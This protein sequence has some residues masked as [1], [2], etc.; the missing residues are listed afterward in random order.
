MYSFFLYVYIYIYSSGVKVHWASDATLYFPIS[1][2]QSS[3][4]FN[5]SFTV[6]VSTVDNLFVSCSLSAV[7]ALITAFELVFAITSCAVI[8]AFLFLSVTVHFP[9]IE[10]FV[11][12]YA[13]NLICVFVFSGAGAGFMF[14]Y[15]FLG[16]TFSSAPVSILKFVF[17]SFMYSSVDHLFCCTVFIFFQYGVHVVVL[18]H[19]MASFMCVHVTSII[20][21]LFLYILAK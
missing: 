4:C 21:F 17:V 9:I 15:T 8:F 3:Y 14:L 2:K 6:V 13:L 7:S 10:M 16:I 5:R 11:L 19:M 1:P 20:F 18:I 12:L